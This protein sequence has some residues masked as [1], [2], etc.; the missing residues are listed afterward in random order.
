MH[1]DHL[2]VV[3]EEE[4][5]AI[6]K[7][8]QALNKG[9]TLILIEPL[10][11]PLLLDPPLEEEAK[12]IAKEGTILIEPLLDPLLLHPPPVV[13]FLDAIQEVWIEDSSGTLS[14]STCPVIF[15]SRLASKQ[16]KCAYGQRKR[17]TMTLTTA[18]PSSYMLSS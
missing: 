3:E 9:G 13:K 15:I 6:A 5:K 16:K 7:E 1:D 11:D 12:A 18:L 17:K 8:V 4:A 10:L 14:L 2:V